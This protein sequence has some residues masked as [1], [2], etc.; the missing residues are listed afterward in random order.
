MKTFHY[1]MTILLSIIAGTFLLSNESEL[2]LWMGL[3]SLLTAIIFLC[4]LMIE[5]QREEIKELRGKV[6][7]KGSK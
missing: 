5:Q 6:I 2:W 1:T 7:N 4:F 3:V